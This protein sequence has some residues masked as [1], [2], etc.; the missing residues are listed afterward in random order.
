MKILRVTLV[1]TT[2]GGASLVW[3]LTRPPA[4]L[5]QP[6][7]FACLAESD[8]R[9]T[10]FTAPTRQIYGIGLSYAAHIEE[11]A[12]EFDPTAGPA[13]FR[14]AITTLQR[15]PAHVRIPAPAEI[16]QLAEE[17]EPG[18]GRELARRHPSLPALLDYEGELGFVLLADVS[19]QELR[20]PNFAPPL[21]FFV[22]NDLSARVLA[23][24]G[25]GRSNRYEYWGLSKSL[26]GFL[27]ISDRVWIPH[28][29]RASSIPCIMLT[30][31]VNGAVH[32]NA[33]T[34]DMIYTPLEMLRAI[35]AAYPNAELKRGDRIV[36]GTPGGVAM[37]T[38]RWKARLAH[39]LGFDRF[40]KLRFVL[41]SDTA[42]FL[43]SG[44]TVVVSGEWLGAAT[45]RV[46]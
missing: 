31:R 13:V 20:N 3:L 23:V 36:T 39:L 4:I 11:T 18:L 8:G 14:K 2:L 26:P 6:A 19:P 35:H 30:T 46:Q 10:D 1:L 37:E 5:P 33:S 16:L 25:E 41:R 7:N 22:G 9:F 27:P 28:V 43:Q 44:D 17:F 45:V 42:R 40:T 29:Q 38:L 15:S 12:H 32:Q 21:G 24:P 34:R